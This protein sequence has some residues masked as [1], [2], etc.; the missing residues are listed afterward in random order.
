MT[1]KLRKWPEGNKLLLL[2]VWLFGGEFDQKGAIVYGKIVGVC[3]M[4]WQV[5]V[6]V[7]DINGCC[8]AVWHGKCSIYKEKHGGGAR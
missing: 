6:I 7:K 2:T 4:G 1:H 8:S 3:S 5:V